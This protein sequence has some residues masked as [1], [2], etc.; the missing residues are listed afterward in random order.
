MSNTMEKKKFS[1]RP[2]ILGAVLLAAGYFGFTKINYLL[3]NE[4][5]ENSFLEQNIVP[6]LPKIGGY[7]VG[8]RVKENQA[9]RKGD[10]LVVIDDRDLRIKVVQAELALKNAEANVAL[11]QSNAG[12][13]GANVG[14]SD[15][16][17]QSYSAGT[18]AASAGVG[19]AEANLEAARVRV[20]KTVLDFNRY[21]ALLA[22]KAVTQQQYD[23]VKAEKE[24]AEALVAVAAKQVEAAQRQVEVTQR[25][26]N[27]GMKQKEASQT[28]VGSAEKQVGFA[29]TLV[30]QRR[31]ELD[32]AKLNLSYT[33]VTA[34]VSGIVSKKNVQPGQLV[35]AGQP[36]FSL[37]D[38]GDLWITANFKETQLSKFK[39]GQEVK[40]KVDA[41]PKKE[42]V[43]RIESFS[44]ATGAKFSLLPADNASG[45]FVKVVQRV[46]VRISMNGVRDS[47]FVLRAGM[48]VEVVVP[49]K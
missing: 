45:N 5:T 46:P 28:V 44:A 7:V 48:S 37:V 16:G 39:E 2:F 21:A 17:I 49:V 13:A 32:M 10:T 9:V 42:F 27:V 8:L 47:A 6:I 11:V 23:N 12:S 31:A 3:H 19:T 20:R 4:D 22:D 41:Y 26:G 29:R 40:V 36:L 14:V 30:D 38:E 43:G 35:S 24:S 1:P 25:Q 34:P 15:A 18:A 33:V